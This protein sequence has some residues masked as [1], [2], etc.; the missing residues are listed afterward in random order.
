[1]E[2]VALPSLG[3]V[4]WVVVWQSLGVQK[5]MCAAAIGETWPSGV[6]QERVAL[7]AEVV[8]CVGD[9]GTGAAGALLSTTTCCDVA[10]VKFPAA[11][12]APTWTV[13]GPSAI[14]AVA[15]V[16]EPGAE[17]L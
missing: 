16:V 12:V 9:V 15:T 14:P 3:P 7:E 4:G 13:C 6:R 17:R 10:A 2:T 1:M 5:R 11:S 8:C